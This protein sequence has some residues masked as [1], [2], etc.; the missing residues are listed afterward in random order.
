MSGLAAIAAAPLYEASGARTLWLAVAA[1]MLVL[2]AWAARLSRLTVTQP[3]ALT[4]EVPA[5]GA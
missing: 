2:I 4:Y 1:A 3:V 5:P